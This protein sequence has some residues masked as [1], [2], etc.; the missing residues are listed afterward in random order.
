M[1]QTSQPISR[2]SKLNRR[3][4]L[5]LTAGLAGASVLPSRS[6][7]AE[8]PTSA[9]GPNGP[10]RNV[11]FIVADGM[12]NG[13]LGIA[14]HYSR[15]VLGKPGIWNAL[16]ART[17]TRRC[18]VSTH[19]ANSIVTDSAAASSAWS[20][21]VKHDQGSLC[22][23]PSGK[24]LTPILLRAKQNGRA[25]GVVTT[26]T[27]THA[28]PAG[29]YCNV[30]KR[31]DESDIARQLVERP[32]DIALGGGTEFVSDDLVQG[33]KDMVVVR[34]REQLLASALNATHKG[35][36]LV[37]TFNKSHISYALE[38]NETEPSLLD[39]SKVALDRLAESPSGFFLQIEGGRIDHAAHNNDAFALLHDQLDF[40]AALAFAAEFASSRNDT[41]LIA[42]TD[43]ATANPGLTLYGKQGL[44]GLRLLGGGK[45]SFDWIGAQLAGLAKHAS[46]AQR[47]EVL[48]SSVKAATNVEL[49]SEERTY[50]VRSLEGNRTDAFFPRTSLVC[51]LGALLANHTGVSFVSPNHTA[52][53]VEM[54]ALGRGAD[55]LPAFLDNTAVHDW[56]TAALDLAPAKPA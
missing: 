46:T 41:L 44:A 53:L 6:A 13:A 2:S 25:V 30:Q 47:T 9:T 22:V 33:R 55:T 20:T 19:S 7:A 50:L 43:H 31:G 45:H 36:R 8:R 35:K 38:R 52:D 3:G 49:S 37:G 27:V 24:A 21:G 56:V 4:F 48:V 32:I 17:G 12:S 23:D 1:P 16:A 29:F 39:M 5:T 34:T 15:V 11:I 14:D 40:E 28:T 51:Q 26:T 42:T 18:L 10:V 54:L